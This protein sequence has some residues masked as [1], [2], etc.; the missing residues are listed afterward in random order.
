[1][2]HRPQRRRQVQSPR[3]DMAAVSDDHFSRN[4]LDA[5]CFALTVPPERLRIH[6]PS[7]LFLENNLSRSAHEAS[8][9]LTFSDGVIITATAKRS[10][11][12]KHK[13]Q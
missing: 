13:C 12:F 11:Y 5:L 2:H 1:M 6:S 8:V 4:Y 3:F 7:E 9:S 10:V